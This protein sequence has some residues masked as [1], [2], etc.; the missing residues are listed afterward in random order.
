MNRIAPLALAGLVALVLGACGDRGEAPAGQ[1]AAVADD[2][3]AVVEQAARHL[4]HA[5]IAEVV[6][7][8]V[9]PARLEEMRQRWIA[10]RDSEPPS[11]EEA[12]E[13]EQTMAK[14]TADD[15]VEQ[16]MAEAEPHLAKFDAEVAPQ[17][18]L[19]IGMGRGFAAQ[20]IQENKEFSDAQKQQA[21]ETLDAVAKWLGQAK[22]SDRDTARRAIERV[23]A[24]A[25]ELD[26]ATVDQVQ[27][28]D[29]DQMLGKAG[30][31]FAAVKD[32]VG[33][34]GL[35]LDATFDSVKPSLVKQDGDSATVKVEYTLFGE[36]LAFETEMVRVDGRWYGRDTLAQL[37]RELDDVEDAA[38][39][40]AD[41]TAP[42]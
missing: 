20:A 16:L 9:P 15:A 37:E 30:I 1:A 12:A 41:A 29:F 25:R 13:F 23:V 22:F 14:L 19:M 10:E 5:E 35:D 26:L 34:Y 39:D 28:M 8:S 4:K 36:P 6:A 11:A 21:T 18:P 38:E 33:Y 17:L 40:D 2:P 31:G 27:Q 42:E 24:G 32:V 3:V 7:L